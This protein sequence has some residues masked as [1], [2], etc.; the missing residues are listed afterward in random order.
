MSE[1]LDKI[2]RAAERTAGMGVIRQETSPIVETFNGAV[3][4]EGI[5]HTFWSRDDTVYAWA[6]EADPEPQYVTVLAKGK[7]NSPLAAVRVWLVSQAR[8]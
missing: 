5:V 6:V 3:V 2:E 4:G 8:K 1:L 7:I